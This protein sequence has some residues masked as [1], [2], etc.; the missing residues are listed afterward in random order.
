MP[1]VRPRARQRRAVSSDARVSLPQQDEGS[2]HRGA[3]Q[4]GQLPSTVRDVPSSRTRQA[5]VDTHRRQRQGSQRTVSIQTLV[6]SRVVKFLQPTGWWTL[7]LR[8]REWR[9]MTPAERYLESVRV[10]TRQR[11]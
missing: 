8:W 9:S 2:S 7:V 1:R 5:V 11:L 6:V 4:Y 3:H 10:D